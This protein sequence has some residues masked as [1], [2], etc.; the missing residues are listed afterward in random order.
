VVKRVS[1]N[2]P[3]EEAELQKGDIIEC[4]AEPIKTLADLK[5]ALYYSE[6][7]SKYKIQ[8]K[9]D[10]KTLHKGIELF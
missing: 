6:M 8:I 2:S 1:H 4:F 3:A 9:R 5:I 10:D 7:G